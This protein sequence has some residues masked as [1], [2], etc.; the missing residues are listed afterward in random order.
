[1][2]SDMLRMREEEFD[3]LSASLGRSS[4]GVSTTGGSIGQN[5]AGAVDAGLLGNSV[6]TISKQMKAISGSISNVQNIVQQHSSQMFSYDRAMASK[7]GEIEVPND[8]V[9][10]DSAEV[11]T[12]TQALVAKM[13]GQSVNDGQEAGEFEEI[14]DSS[15][16]VE[17][18][19]DIH[20]DVTVRQRYDDASSVGGQEGIFN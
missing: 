1:M 18:M 12:Y 11:N 17:M 10:N 3:T 9:A 7:I 4:E 13:D 14:A 8:F 19:K 5:F 16:T 15:V 20:G 6:S 2:A